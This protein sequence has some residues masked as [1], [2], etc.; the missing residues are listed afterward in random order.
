MFLR[1]NFIKFLKFYHKIM[2]GR[3]QK[4]VYINTGKKQ[5]LRFGS[6]PKRNVL[7]GIKS[8]LVSGESARPYDS[9]PQWYFLF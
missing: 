1:I 9:Y 7:N 5:I 4:L 6:F 2:T 3:K 8:R